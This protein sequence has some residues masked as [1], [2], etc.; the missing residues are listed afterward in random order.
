MFLFVGIEVFILLE[1]FFA[2]PENKNRTYADIDALYASRIPARKF[3][4]YIVD[5]GVA[6]QKQA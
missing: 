1:V 3:S 6:I 5:D 4:E 2:E